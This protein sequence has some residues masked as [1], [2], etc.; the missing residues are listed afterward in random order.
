MKYALINGQKTIAEPTLKGKCQYCDS[1]VV[2]KCGK[3]N[4]WHWA[5]I[6]KKDCDKWWENET[7]WHR[8]WKNY[9]NIKNQ[10]VIHFSEDGEKHI[11]DIKTDDGL[12]IE[13]Q[14][15]SISFEEIQSRNNFYKNIIWI[16]NGDSFRERFF[17]LHQLPD[18]DSKEMQDIQIMFE[19]NKNHYPAFYRVSENAKD[20]KMVITHSLSDISELVDKQYIGHHLFAWKNSRINW[21]NEGVPIYFD[22]G[23]N[24]LY[25][26]ERYG[27]S[28]VF[29]MKIESKKM[30]V[31]KNGGQYSYKGDPTSF[32]AI[33]LK[34]K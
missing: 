8:D 31:E 12:V 5:H 15:S 7:E 4:I 22:F 20:A 13:L 6:P 21:Y 27:K 29:C 3:I 33:F 14:N 23:D 28:K 26:L 19:G 32:N 11:A 16:V 1:T 25:R 18:P 34:G 17:L 10:E 9:F 2:A 30:L 24:L